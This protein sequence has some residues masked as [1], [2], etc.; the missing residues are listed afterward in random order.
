ME[1]IRHAKCKVHIIIMNDNVWIA[2]LVN[3]IKFN[4]SIST[5]TSYY[6]EYRITI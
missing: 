5:T 3:I 6:Y 4:R 1:S 2:E